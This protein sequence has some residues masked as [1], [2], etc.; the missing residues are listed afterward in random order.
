[1][2]RAKAGWAGTWV[3]SGTLQ[4]LFPGEMVHFVLRT[5]HLCVAGFVHGSLGIMYMTGRMQ[6]VSGGPTGSD[7]TLRGTNDGV[8]GNSFHK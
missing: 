6:S 7:L 3:P 8:P 4:G 5:R 2:V 1:M